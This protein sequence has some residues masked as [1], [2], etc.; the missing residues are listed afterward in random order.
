MED[1]RSFDQVGMVQLKMPRRLTGIQS[2]PPDVS[3]TA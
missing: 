2:Q 3:S 1:S